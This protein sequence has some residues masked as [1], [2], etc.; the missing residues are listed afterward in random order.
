MGEECAKINIFIVLDRLNLCLKKLRSFLSKYCWDYEISNE[1]FRVVAR[2]CEASLRSF[3]KAALLN[4]TNV[5]FC[6]CSISVGLALLVSRLC[7]L[8]H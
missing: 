4:Q 3:Q 7:F 6:L 2:D 5:D 1:I 8:D